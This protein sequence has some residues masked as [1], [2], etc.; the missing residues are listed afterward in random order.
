M[1]G[2]KIFGMCNP[3]L[4][5]VLK[6]SPDRIKDLGLK[7]GSTTL[8]N[9]E[10]VFKLISDIISNNEDAN[11][12]AGGSLLNAFRVCKELS[13]K[14][15][16]NKDESISVFFSGGISDDSGGILLQELL[17]EIGIKFEFHITNKA[18]LETAKCVVFVTEE[19][20]TLLAGLGAA[21]EYSITTFESENI[22]H[23]LKT[24]NIFATSGFFVEVCFQAILKSAQY[25][26]Q[27][28][29]N[30]C[31]FVFGLSA[32]YI[33]EKY[34]NELF[35]LLP[36]ID[37]IIGNQEEFV[38]LYKSINNILQI[39]DDDQLLLSQDNINQPE[40]DALER[41]LTE[42]HKHLKPT[43]IILCTRAHLPVISFNPKDPN[44]YI[45]YHECIHVPKERLIDVN[46]CGDAFNGGLIYGISNS[47]PLDA[48]I[49]MGHYAASNVAQNVGCDFDFS[50]KPTLSEIIQLTSSKN[51]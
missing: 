24:A 14:D 39:E 4:D 7:I 17:T 51:N 2:K 5:I 31:S 40:N 45:K 47:Y 28:R 34:M 29:S 1:R 37:Y 11:F 49:Y 12:V 44:S 46:G 3:I 32:T 38:S 15:E 16:K 8:G 13:N 25:I 20:R 21:K 10:E 41:I 35:Q 36:M 23:A 9:D 22:Q 30:E 42:I 19:E 48:S 43:C 18:N 27:F 6:A 33:P 26:H 50:N